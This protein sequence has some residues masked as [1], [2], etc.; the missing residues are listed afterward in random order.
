MP[1]TPVEHKSVHCWV[2]GALGQLGSCSLVYMDD[3][4]VHSTKLEQHLL[5]VMKV[6]KIFPSRS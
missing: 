5:Y 6:L 3:C 2:L 1:S 4:L